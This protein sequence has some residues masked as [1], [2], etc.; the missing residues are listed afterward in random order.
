MS[1]IKRPNGR[2]KK[3]TKK[4]LDDLSEEIVKFFNE[5]EEARHIIDFCV[6]KGLYKSRIQEFS[7]DNDN[8]SVSLKKVKTICEHRIIKNAYNMKNPT[9]AIF[10]LKCNYGY[11]DKQTVEQTTN[12]NISGSLA[13]ALNEIDEA[14]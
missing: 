1:K 11:I 9:F 12:L 2:P 8:F 14:K 10:D 6:Y 5:N 13:Q 7:R 4:Y 3:Y